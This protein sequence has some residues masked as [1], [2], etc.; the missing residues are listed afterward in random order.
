M[1]A[2]VQKTCAMLAMSSTVPAQPDESA[3][4]KMTAT[5]PPPAVTA[6]A[7]WTA[8]RKASRR[9]QPPIAE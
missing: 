6:S 1:Q 4:L 3:W 7:S 9:N 5:P 8:K 2:A